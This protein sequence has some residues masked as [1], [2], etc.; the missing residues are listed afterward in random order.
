MKKRSFGFFMACAVSM[1]LTACGHEHI[2]NE[3]TCIAP[4][5]CEECG[6]TEG[7]KRDHM[8]VE[9]TCS[10][11]KHCSVCGEAEGEVLE[12]SWVEAT[13]K[14]A[15]HCSSCGQAEGEALAHDL[16][17][18]NYQQSAIC[19]ICGEEV[20]E[21]LQ[22]DFD[23]YGI[24]CVTEY[25]KEYMYI[26]GCW[27]GNFNGEKEVQG[28]VS[29]TKREINEVEEG[30]EELEG[31]EWICVDEKITFDDDVARSYGFYYSISSQDYYTPYEE[32]YTDDSGMVTTCTINYNG[33]KY[34]D[35][36]IKVE[37]LSGEW[38]ND[39]IYTAIYRWSAR[40]PKEY[41]GLVLCCVDSRQV[42]E[43][44]E[45]QLIYD[46]MDENTIFFH[47]E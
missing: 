7:D 16:S 38:S 20:G 41:D 31:Y 25:D 22:A 13:C 26:T 14:E 10:E 33:Q 45:E 1:L 36:I 19:K 17:E 5:T 8:W 34:E 40:L 35:C 11:P 43:V 2:W 28:T 32:E 3:A 18:P 39:D 9:A 21:P 30:Y 24:E 23:K 15:K 4:K 6:K 46:Y 29:F 44:T 27:I 37:M 42:A 12:H 47:V